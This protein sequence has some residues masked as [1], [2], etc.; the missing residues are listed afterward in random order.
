MATKETLVNTVQFAQLP[1]DER[2]SVLEWQSAMEAVDRA[3]SKF[4]E[5]RN[6]SRLHATVKGWRNPRAIQKKYYAWIHADKSWEVLVNWAK[7]PRLTGAVDTAL[8]AAYKTYA[9]RNQRSGRQGHRAML[10]DLRSGKYIEGVG[11]WEDVWR[12]KYPG[13]ALPVLCPADW[14]PPGWNYEN[15]Q[16]RF[17][18]SSYERANAT[19]GAVAARQFVPPVYSTRVGLPVAAEYQF[20][21]MWDDIVVSVPGV[22]K[23]L[24][25]PLQFRCID[26]ASTHLVSVGMKPQILRDD[27]SREGL[28]KGLFKAT[29]ADVL[30][31]I[32]YR[33]EG[34]VF[35]IEHGTASLSD[36]EC[37][38]ITRLTDGKV[39]FRRSDVLGKQVNDGVFPGQGHGNFKAKALLESLHR[40]PHFAAA[41]LPGQTGSNSRGEKVESLYGLEAYAGKLLAA[42]DRIPPAIRNQVSYG[43]AL[44]FAIYR[45]VMF[46]LYNL[47]DSRTDHKME[48]WEENGWMKEMWTLDGANWATVDAIEALPEF[49]REAARRALTTP[50]YHKG[51]RLSP[52]EVWDMSADRLE[53]LP[54]C[55]IID[56][57][58]DDCYRKVTVGH[59]H[60]IEFQDRDI[61][62]TAQVMRYLAMLVQPDGSG[63][64]LREGAEYGLYSL[65]HDPSKAVVVDAA[66]RNVLG[67]VSQWT[68]VMPANA[69]QVEAAIASQNLVREMVNAPIIER[70][71]EEAAIALSEQQNNKIILEGVFTERQ[72]GM[73]VPA[74]GEPKRPEL[75]TQKR[76]IE[77]LGTLAA[78]KTVVP[79]TDGDDDNGN[80][81]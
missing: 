73:L 20:D 38:L 62:G 10:A 55:A 39:T 3:G 2:N 9:E 43:G 53:R 70:H 22:N 68:S 66:R 4:A 69:K 78:L 72:D 7:V 59:K 30:C 58:G 75:S 13:S 42:Y 65:P 23:R 19:T 35:V 32:G 33:P 56:F 76:Q 57:L 1:V 18:L 50:G 24:V 60:L 29:V 44:P 21:D 17:P 40:L 27:N 26:R 41:A 52:K 11:T 34:T 51:V 16:R 49:S 31:N 36:A 12:A 47:I 71:A 77:T 46:E 14:V 64:W 5:C 67:M 54:H 80:G 63:V 15:L 81:W 8:G 79:S 37:E 28:G 6:Q 45:S 25:R 48:G 74:K 61:F